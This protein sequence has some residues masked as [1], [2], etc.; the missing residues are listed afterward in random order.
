MFPAEATAAYP[1]LLLMATWVGRWSQVTQVLDLLEAAERL[2]A[3]MP[4]QPEHALHLSGEIDT[5]RA[6]VAYQAAADPE[7]AIAFARWALA[8]T[9]RAWYWVR[10][11]AWLYLAVA[12]QMA[13][14]LD[15]AYAV[16][17]EAE[18]EDVAEDGAV[19]ARLALSPGFVD[20]MA[21]NLQTIPRRATHGLA[22]GETHHR[23][24]SL[25]WAHYFLSS[26]AYQ[27]NDLPVAEAHART[28]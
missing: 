2:V 27:H 18:P 3:Q 22:V 5:M 24:E 1:D 15:Q 9:P 20:W 13:G 16:M 7:N 28:M 4:D 6:I 17:A 10:S 25:G 21:G 11:T 14:R 26:V 8:T 19:H 12:H 23:R